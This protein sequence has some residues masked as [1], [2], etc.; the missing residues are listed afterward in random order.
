[1]WCRIT[2]AGQI[3]FRLT[4]MTGFIADKFTIDYMIVKG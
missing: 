4:G 3:T 2:A 1:V